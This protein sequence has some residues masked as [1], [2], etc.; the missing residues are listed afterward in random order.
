MRA[1]RGSVGSRAGSRRR[2]AAV[3]IALG[4]TSGTISALAKAAAA[5]AAAAAATAASCQGQPCCERR[6][7]W[8]NSLQEY[9][10][11]WYDP[12]RCLRQDARADW[13]TGRAA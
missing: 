3:C 8:D 9:A 13:G 10:F 7:I 6:S 11:P 5:A 4:T 1:G 2:R 12:R